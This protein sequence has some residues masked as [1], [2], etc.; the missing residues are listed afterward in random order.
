MNIFIF[1]V[2]FTLQEDQSVTLLG[3]SALSCEALVNHASSPRI[4]AKAMLEHRS[5]DERLAGDT[6]AT[7]EP[8]TKPLLIP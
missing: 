5:S 3:K 8:I 7:L 2:L 6:D 4:P 1:S